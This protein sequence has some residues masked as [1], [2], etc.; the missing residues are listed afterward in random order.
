MLK[1]LYQRFIAKN[2]LRSDLAIDTLFQNEKDDLFKNAQGVILELGAGRGINNKYFAHA[3]K[4]ILS[5]PNPF[6]RDLIDP[7]SGFIMNFFAEKIQLPDESIDSVVCSMTLCTIRNPQQALNEIFRVLRPSGS[8]YFFE[9]V[10][11]K[12]GTVTR[13]IQDILCP[14]CEF[15][16]GGCRPN[17]ETES[18]IQHSK[19]IIRE[20]HHFSADLK[21]CLLQDLISGIAEKP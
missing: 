12:R 1:K 2:L 7:E 5:E 3:S 14:L 21:T 10:G 17:R 15:F 20:I 4:I 19:L 6:L 16:D 8:L 18:I 9:H 13:F 11:A